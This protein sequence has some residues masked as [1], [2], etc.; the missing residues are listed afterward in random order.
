ML[1]TLLFFLQGIPEVS[2]EIALSLALAGVS[3]RWGIIAVTGTAFV[4]VIYMIRSL[5][6]TF[7]IHSVVGILIMIL[8]IKKATR[9]KTAKCF[10]VVLASFAT[11]ATLEILL[12]ELFSYIIKLDLQ[13]LTPNSILWKLV[14]LPQAILMILFALLVSKYKKPLEGMWK[15]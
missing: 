6:F 4:I 12:S 13:F 11:L 8:F 14:G 10:I 3:L 7:G 5:P 2:G 1:K 9:V 15:I